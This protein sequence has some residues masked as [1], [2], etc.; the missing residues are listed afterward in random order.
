M[1]TPPPRRAELAAIAGAVFLSAMCGCFLYELRR[2]DS[3]LAALEEAQAAVQAGRGTS[4]AREG[5]GRVQVAAA[6]PAGSAQLPFPGGPPGLARVGPAA[7]P[8]TVEADLQRLRETVQG[9]QSR[10]DQLST[11]TEQ[12]TQVAVA[13][14][15]GNAAATEGKEAVEKTQAA[16]SKAA[17]KAWLR[18]EL[19]KMEQALALEAAQREN[20]RGLVEELSGKYLPD[21]QTQ[22]EWAAHWTEFSKEWEERLKSVMTADQQVKY[23]AY[24]AHQREEQLATSVQWTVSSMEE[25]VGLSTDQKDRVRERVQELYGGYYA[26]AATGDVSG[27]D[28]EGFRTSLREQMSADQQTKFDEWY[29]A[30][31]NWAGGS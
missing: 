26:K 20:V 3:R 16:T 11:H 4:S 27:W 19:D 13:Q 15:A 10:L 31:M 9:L 28:A 5:R 22:Q 17:Y 7:P 6:V 2:L 18:M 25:A 23:A 8:P 30:N 29:A 21:S 24:Q 14:A 1:P 12:L